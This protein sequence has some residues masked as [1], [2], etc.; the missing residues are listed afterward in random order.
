MIGAGIRWG[1]AMTSELQQLPSTMQQLRQGVDNFEETTRLMAG[2]AARLNEILDLYSR[3]LGEAA[4]RSS[5]VARL[6][7]RQIDAITETASPEAV[8]GALGEV[9]RAVE[10]MARL[11]PLWPLVAGARDDGAG[12]SADD[13]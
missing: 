1:A 11:N 7:Q 3:A 5:D 2:N 10:A 12:D 8:R 6:M 9:G 13:S 4:S